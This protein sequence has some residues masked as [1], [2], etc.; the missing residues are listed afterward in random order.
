MKPSE[1]YSERVADWMFQNGLAPGVPSIGEV[2]LD[3]RFLEAGR[4]ASLPGGAELPCEIYVAPGG[5]D[6]ARPIPVRSS[7]SPYLEA[8][9]QSMTEQ[10][11]FPYDRASRRAND[12]ALNVNTLT[13]HAYNCFGVRRILQDL[14]ER[15]VRG[16][17]I[18]LVSGYET[19][20]HDLVESDQVGE[21]LAVDLSRQACEV[22]AEKYAGHPNAEKLRLKLF[23]YSGLDP[24]FQECESK[25]LA[26]GL[27]ND[28]LRVDAVRQHFSGLIGFVA[29]LDR[30]HAPKPV[31]VSNELLTLD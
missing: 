26:Q 10:W 12:G 17:R 3:P 23:D 1:T 31:F 25:E 22:I 18:L 16:A 5:P 7:A 19:P 8:L 30:R 27:N 6:Q 4:F 20:V 24:R 15:D 9:G 13:R 2:I 14:E 21:V 28:R 11:S 29:W